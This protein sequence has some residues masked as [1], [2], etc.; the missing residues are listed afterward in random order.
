SPCPNVLALLT[1]LQIKNCQYKEIWV[2]SLVA[3]NLIPSICYDLNS[4]GLSQVE[5]YLF[6]DLGT[7]TVEVDEF[8]SN[9]DSTMDKINRQLKISKKKKEPLN[10]R[11]YA[12][13]ASNTYLQKS[14]AQSDLCRFIAVSS[15]T[16]SLLVSDL[17]DYF[18]KERQDP[19]QLEKLEPKQHFHIQQFISN[20]LHLFIWKKG[21]LGRTNL[22]RHQIN[23]S[24]ALPIKQYPYRYSSAKK[25][26]IKKELIYMLT[27][28]II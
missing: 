10:I 22:V 8:A 11:C 28:K 20:N 12:D 13:E 7:M 15:E 16:K 17:F 4:D 23:T 2:P 26:I 5:W 21:P 3:E 6:L 24:T 1:S 18:Y 25:D 9:T 19:Y 14:N 27:K